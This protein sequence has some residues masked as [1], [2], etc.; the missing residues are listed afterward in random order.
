MLLVKR[1]L[2]ANATLHGL[3]WVKSAGNLS[4]KIIQRMHVVSLLLELHRTHSTESLFSLD[5]LFFSGLED[6]FVLDTEFPSLDIEAI[7]S[8]H[9]GVCVFR[10]PEVGKSEATESTCLV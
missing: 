8:G 4:A 9:D 7:Q 2:E 10:G 1:A 5:A 6:L 3:R